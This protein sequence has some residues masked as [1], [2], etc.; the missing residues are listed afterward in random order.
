MATEQ[1]TI[2]QAIAQAAIETRKAAVKEVMV[3][4]EEVTTGETNEAASMRPKIGRSLL[5][6]PTLHWSST[7]KYVELRLGLQFLEDLT[8]A[9]QEAC[10]IMESTFE[11]LS[12][13]FRQ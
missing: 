11:T 1:A 3:A 5:K 6:Q 10:N 13:K 4:R 8:Q 7:D 2:T 9:K 12:N